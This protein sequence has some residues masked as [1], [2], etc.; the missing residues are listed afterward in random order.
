MQISQELHAALVKLNVWDQF[1]SSVRSVRSFEEA[2]QAV[3]QFKEHARKQ[4]AQL[5]LKAHPDRGGNLDEMQALSA[6]YSVV[7]KL[8]V[9]RP[10]PPPMVTFIRVEFGSGGFRTSST[11]GTSTSTSWSGIF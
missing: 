9:Q 7:K 10:A 11:S 6:A 3:V 8:N 4:F 5:S 2:E 1:L